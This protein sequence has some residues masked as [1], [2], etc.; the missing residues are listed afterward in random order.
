MMVLTKRAIWNGISTILL[1][2]SPNVAVMVLGAN[3][4]LAGSTCHVSA[5]TLKYFLPPGSLT[6]ALY[7]R[8]PDC[9]IWLDSYKEEYNGLLNTKLHLILLVK[10]NTLFCVRNMAQRQFHPCARLL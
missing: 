5:S 2:V 8:N 9:Q 3:I 1:G 7:S 6:K 10:T 4:Q